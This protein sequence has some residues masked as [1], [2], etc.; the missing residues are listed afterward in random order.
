M[1]SHLNERCPKAEMSAPDNTKSRSRTPTFGVILLTCTLL[2]L[3]AAFYYL[4]PKTT[5][6]SSSGNDGSQWP[7]HED[8]DSQWPI[9]E[10]S[11]WP[12]RKIPGSDF[13]ALVEPFDSVDAIEPFEPFQPVK[14]YS[15]EYGKVACWQDG[16]VWIKKLTPVEMSSL[17]VDRFQ[18]TDRAPEQAGEDAFC[19]RLRM[20]GASFWGLP[21]QWPEYD[22]WCESI[23]GCVEPIK[24]VD[25]EVGF[26]TSGGVWV[27]NTSQGWDKLLPKGLGLRNALTMDERC[28]VIKDLGGRF[29]EDTRVCA[30][31]AP[32]LG[33]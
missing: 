22:L 13:L 7:V 16:G 28:E 23:D 24:K 27:L 9:H 21:P 31:L 10:G 15:L 17:G 1:T 8:L 32:L 29:C 11:Q 6:S 19:T 33:P 2:S 20:Y 30:E 3:A 12:V 5:I 4:Y 14:R 18:D 25:F 26:P